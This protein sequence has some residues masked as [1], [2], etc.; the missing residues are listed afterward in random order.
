[1]GTVEISESM[2]GRESADTVGVPRCRGPFCTN[3]SCKIQDAINEISC[4][5]FLAHPSIHPSIFS[6]KLL[7]HPGLQACW[8]LFQCSK[9]K[10]VRGTVANLNN[11]SNSNFGHFWVLNH[12]DG[13]SQYSLGVHKE[14]HG[15]GTSVLH[16]VKLQ[17][18]PLHQH[19]TPGLISHLKS[20]PEQRMWYER[21]SSR[22]W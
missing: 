3:K 21:G 1:M 10:G 15:N 9:W 14:R 5:S 8:R 13:Y 7:M 12:P 22:G 11:H 20:P 2:G 4:C 16:A 19:G 17:C 18:S 6:P